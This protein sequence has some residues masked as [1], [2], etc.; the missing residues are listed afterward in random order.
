MTDSDNRPVTNL[1]IVEERGEEKK[2]FT[3]RVRL[4]RDRMSSVIVTR[5]I[6]RKMERE[7]ANNVSADGRTHAEKQGKLHQ[8]DLYRSH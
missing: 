3:W 6:A 7:T 2:F 8:L 1:P 4:R 5:S